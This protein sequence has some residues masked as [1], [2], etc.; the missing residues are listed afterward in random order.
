M[1][2]V[3]TSNTLPV[4][5]DSAIPSSNRE[6]EPHIRPGVNRTCNRNSK[7]REGMTSGC[8]QEYCLH[9]LSQPRAHSLGSADVPGGGGDGLGSHGLLPGDLGLR[10]AGHAIAGKPYNVPCSTLESCEK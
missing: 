5:E 8:L 7:S 10:W 9:A 3:I 2:S 6:L 1:V 4:T